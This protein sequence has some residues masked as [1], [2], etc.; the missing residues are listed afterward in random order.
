MMKIKFDIDLMKF[1]SLFEKI[2]GTDAKDCIKQE[3]KLVFIVNAGMAGKAVGKMGANIKKLE[4]IIKKK[5]KIIEYSDDLVEFVM[6]A[7][8]PLKAKDI[9]EENNIVTITPI[10]SQTRGYLIGREAVNLRGYEDIVK[11][12]YNIEKIKVV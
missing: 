3:G 9:K 4:N 6:N 11:R 12:Y 2:T 5:I 7:I 1:I 10:D 8:H